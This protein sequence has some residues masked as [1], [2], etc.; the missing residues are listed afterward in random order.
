MNIQAAEKPGL[1][2][3]DSA[4]YLKTEED[5]VVY[6]QACMDEAPGDARF[7]AMALGDI[8]KARGMMQLSRDTGLSREGLYKSLGNDANPSF[9]TVLKVMHALGLKLQ[10]QTV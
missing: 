9:A 4:D 3:F 7:I 2:P 6:L 10:V 1:K 8:A 5:C